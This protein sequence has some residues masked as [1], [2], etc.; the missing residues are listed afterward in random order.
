MPHRFDGVFRKS[1]ETEK[2]KC[3]L[4]KLREGSKPVFEA[5]VFPTL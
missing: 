5:K 2:L 3:I 1:L 4:L